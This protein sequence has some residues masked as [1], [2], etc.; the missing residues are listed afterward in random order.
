VHTWRDISPRVVHVETLARGADPA[1]R[2]DALVAEI[3][4]GR[5]AP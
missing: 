1:E 5:F 4:A 3:R 2:I